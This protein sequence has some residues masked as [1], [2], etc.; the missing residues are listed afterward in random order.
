MEKRNI[1][2]A[3]KRGVAALACT[4]LPVFAANGLAVPEPEALWP[5][6]QARIAVQTGSLSPV[7]LSGQP[8]NALIASN[9][10]NVSGGSAS[11]GLQGGAVLGDYYFAKPSF[12]AFRAS[13]GLLIGAQGGAPLLNTMAG[14]HV[15]LAVNSLGLSG[16]PPGLDGPGTVPYV[17]LGFTG[18]VWRSLA[19][20]A[21]LG[22]VA[23]R[24]AHAG[25][26]GRAVFGNQ[27]MDTALREMRLS[28]VMQVGVRYTF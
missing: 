14:S 3:F 6:W 7:T 12:G 9:G 11:R 8:A 21:D 13:G 24:P 19:I 25:G 1:G 26:V 4:S 22:L 28:P 20:T 17:G 10:A 27:G 18:G 5:Q 23:E 2:L 15:E 16:A